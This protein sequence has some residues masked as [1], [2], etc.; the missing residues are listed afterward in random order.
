MGDFEKMSVPELGKK[1][2]KL[3]EYL[4]DIEEERRLVLGQKGIHLSSC[5]VRKY[6]AEIEEINQHINEL[7][8]LLQKKH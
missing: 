4:E 5:T 3:K 1:L 6:E 7:E 8:E 2:T